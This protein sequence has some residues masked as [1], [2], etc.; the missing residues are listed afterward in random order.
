MLRVGDRAAAAVA[1]LKNSQRFLKARVYL[2]DVHVYLGD[3]RVDVRRCGHVLFHLHQYLVELL[4]VERVLRDAGRRCGER[5]HGLIGGLERGYRLFYNAVERAGGVVALDVLGDAVGRLHH[6]VDDDFKIR[7]VY[8]G[9]HAFR[10][11]V[12]YLRGDGVFLRVLIVCN[13]GLARPLR[14]HIEHVVGEVLINDDG[15]VVFA[16]VHA[17]DRLLLVVEE[18]PV[19]ARRL[20]EVVEHLV[21]LIRDCAVIVNIA[22]IHGGEGDGDV[23]GVAVRVPVGVDVQPSVEAGQ[24]A[25]RQ[26]YSHGKKVLAERFN[27]I[28]EDSQYVPHNSSVSSTPCADIQ[29]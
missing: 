6:S 21:A 26:R 13:A 10:G 19:D 15:G 1:V 27:V 3:S 14:E 23:A 17:V 28:F 2:V 29:P 4:R 5:R 11:G 8:R 20:A 22:L 24:Q 18:D 7:L 25:Y 16:G 9:L 12:G